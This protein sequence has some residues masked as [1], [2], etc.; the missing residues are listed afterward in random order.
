MISVLLPPAAGLP[1]ARR[2]ERLGF[3]AHE[4]SPDKIS[5][6]DAG[7]TEAVYLLPSSAMA[8]E[9]WPRLRVRLAHAN[10]YFVGCVPTASTE[11]VVHF[12]RDGAHDVVAMDDADQRW[13]TALEKAAA[14]Q[15]LWVQLYG[16]RPLSG[17][18][19]LIGPSDGLQRLRASIKKLGPT[20]VRVLIQGESGVGKE[21]VASTL[22]ESGRGGR[23][24]ALNCAAI[25]KDL[26]EA[27]LFGVEKGAYTGA[28]KTRPGLVEQADNGTLFLDEVGETDLA[29]Q[30]K[31]LRFL[32][33][34]RARR[35]GDEREY[36]VRVR[37]ISATNRD[38]EQEIGN[39]RFRADLYYRLAEIILQVPPLRT[40]PEDLPALSLA[41]MQ[42]ANERFGKNF[43]TLEPG[44]ISRF[45]T[46]HWPGNVRELKSVIDR[47]VLMFDCP[48]LRATWWPSA[49]QKLALAKRLLAESGNDYG[50]VAAQLGI[51]PSTLY[52]WRKAGKVE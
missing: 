21:L 6:L 10:R 8:Q 35:V 15:K 30:P 49:R 13:V 16:G 43:E 39:N 50:W 9:N 14:D 44:L 7:T 42:Q 47:L 20:D 34:G 1:L 22:H 18:E 4:F 45:Q 31:L 36:S 52:R 41:F 38:L 51:N 12:L 5:E 33:T 24:V 40:R 26:L 19:V 23:F 2:L 27:E 17:R 32:E 3:A 28:L 11:A 46:Y 48:V 29:L 25:P 37:V